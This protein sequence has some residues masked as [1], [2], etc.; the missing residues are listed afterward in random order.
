LTGDGAGADAAS[1][2]RDDAQQLEHPGL[3]D[4]VADEARPGATAFLIATFTSD[5]PMP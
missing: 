5:P 3:R 1:L 4:R 2:E